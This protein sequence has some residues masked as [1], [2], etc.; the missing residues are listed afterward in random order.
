MPEHD[1]S[2]D[3]ADLLADVAEKYFLEGKIQAEIAKEIGVTRSMVSRML[4]EARQQGIVSIQV[5]RPLRPHREH[6]EALVERF[7]LKDAYVVA[8]RYESHPQLL[9]LLGAAGAHVLTRYLVPDSVIGIVWGTS[10]SA[11]VDALEFQDGVPVTVVQLIGALGVRGVEYDGHALIRQLAAKLGGEAIYLN[12]PAVMETPEMVSALLENQGLREAIALA[13]RCDVA[14]LGI[15]NTNPDDCSFCRTGYLS[16]EELGELVQ[17][18]AVGNVYGRYFDE[19]G[20]PVRSIFHDRVVGID[21]QH[22]LATPIRIGV[23]GGAG[24]TEAIAGALRGGFVNVLVTDSVVAA[25]LNRSR[26]MR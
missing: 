7:G 5:R 26:K 21:T 17:A 2:A 13:Q 18:G 6:A 20:R 24:K 4:T 15:G 1:R 25:G 10:T 14:I 16:L 22:L 8:N 12:A 23:A 3:R 9:R 11:L 19:T